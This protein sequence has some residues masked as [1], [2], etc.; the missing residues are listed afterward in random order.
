MAEAPTTLTEE[1]QQRK[2]L[3]VRNLQEVLGADRLEKHLISGK[4]IHLYWG[5][6][7]TGRPHVG[8][9]VPMQKIADF[10]K[11]G[12]RVTILFADLHG[13]L[14]NLKST[15]ELLENRVKYYEHVIKALLE[16]FDVPLDKLHFVK[17]SDY[18]LKE[19]YTKEVLRLCGQVSQRDALKAGAEVVKQV[20][21]PLL[22]G[23]MY[24]LL[25][26]LDE[27]FLKV[28]AQFGGVDQRKI[29][30]LAEEQLPKLKLGKRYHF[31]NPMVPGLTGSKMSSSEV[32]SKID[33]LDPPDV[34]ERKIM[35][36]SCP[37]KAESEDNGVLSFYEFVVLTTHEKV[38]FDNGL[39]VQTAGELR[40]A[41]ENDKVTAEEL[42][43]KLA[44]F[45]NGILAKVQAKCDN[46]EIREIISKG[47][48]PADI[49]DEKVLEKVPEL[50]ENAKKLKSKLE[51]EGGTLAQSK[52][53][54]EKLN[55]G[56]A[57]KVLWRVPVKG[58]VHLGH[59]KALIELQRLQKLGCEVVILL[60]DLGA[61][62]DNEK[63]PWNAREGRIDYYESVLNAML[64]SL[65][66]ENVK[67]RKSLEN[68]FNSDYSIEMYKVVSHIT[69]DE[70]QIVPG[71]SLAV[72][73]I[74]AY[75]FLDAHFADVDVVLT[76]DYDEKYIE[77]SQK[78]SERLSLPLQA[79]LTH[80][81]LEGT[82]GKRMSSTVSDF[83]LDPTDTPKQFKGKIAKSF[84]E[85]GNLQGNV[86]LHLAEA[87]VFPLSE[88]KELT[89]ERA[90]KDG[91][92]ITVKSASE[93]SQ[94][95]ADNKLHPA[96]LKAFVIKRLSDFINPIKA[97]LDAS[98]LAKLL[99][100][101]FPPAPKGGKK[102]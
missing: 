31:M 83:N 2:E 1:Q 64:K 89:I 20:E 22:S 99:K 26:A 14:D 82:D 18:Q 72:N 11:A 85:P 46:D 90:E 45:L 49:P 4:N 41:F 59:L 84:C 102:K 24:P 67:I 44:L 29:F 68:E 52:R 10:L 16:A 93:L 58:R 87:L 54:V 19:D 79:H 37:K 100:A 71:T 36:A 43:S 8:Y 15:F 34:V 98:D 76:A 17:G 9:F 25:Q 91:G 51:E 66:L 77:L 48:V 63:C 78:I 50:N 55:K 80:K 70:S 97:D 39:I 7:T 53:L 23:L 56:E 86:A 75:R 6:A 3:I 35:G 88:E 47:Y 42:K 13:F 60:S 81:T 61:F 65:K 5:S 92:N 74:P 94:I 32:D 38:Q 21:S 95:F 57:P 40:E 30:I 96:D 28:D 12:I 101:A 33:L 27:V 73:L 69:R 62:L